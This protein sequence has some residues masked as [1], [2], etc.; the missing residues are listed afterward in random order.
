MLK[1]FNRIGA[2]FVH[3]YCLNVKGILPSAI[4]SLSSCTFEKGRYFEP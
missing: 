1:R 3:A 4:N 2:V